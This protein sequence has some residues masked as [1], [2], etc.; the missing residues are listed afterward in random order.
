MLVHNS[1]DLKSLAG[2]LLYL[3]TLPQW[4]AGGTAAPGVAED[5]EVAPEQLALS[6]S[7]VEH[8]SHRPSPDN[9]P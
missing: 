7:V 3:A 9:A 5:P 4:R 6:L 8:K 2:V 1:Q